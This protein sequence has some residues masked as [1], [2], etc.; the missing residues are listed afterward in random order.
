M[1][2]LSRKEHVEPNL[3]IQNVVHTAKIP[4]ATR[5]G[6]TVNWRADD[7]FSMVRKGAG[8]H[9]Q[10][11]HER[12]RPEPSWCV[13]V[14]P[15]DGSFDRVVGQRPMRQ[16]RADA[17]AEGEMHWIVEIEFCFFLCCLSPW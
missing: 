4:F 10:S 5:K 11:F 13:K 2:G 3:L 15:Q 1:R 12:S 7:F 14:G 16:E 6:G 17:S 8:P 9:P